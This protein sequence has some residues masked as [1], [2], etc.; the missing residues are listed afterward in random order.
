MSNI[1][2]SKV[3]DLKFKLILVEIVSDAYRLVECGVWLPGNSYVLAKV[4]ES[5]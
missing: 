4:P 2:E 5:L 3:W 1:A